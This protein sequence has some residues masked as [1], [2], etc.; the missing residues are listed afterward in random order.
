M[1]PLKKPS[2]KRRRTPIGILAFQGGFAEHQTIL[3]S[4]GYKV[5]LVRTQQDLKL[6]NK[7]IIPGGESTTMGLFLEKTGLG[8]EIRK[9]ATAKK[10]PLYIWGTCAGAI[11]LA[12]EIKSTIVPPHLKLMDITIERNAYGTQLD[13][14]HTEIKVPQLKINNLQGTFIRAPIIKKTA[15]N[16]DILAKHQDAIILVRQKNLLASTFHPELCNEKRLH[17]Y[18]VEME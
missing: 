11:L 5:L 9:R 7:L 2:I 17:K 13:S 15:K 14:F 1:S 8:K 10:N 4:L 16:V 18:F 6:T 12:K 3:E